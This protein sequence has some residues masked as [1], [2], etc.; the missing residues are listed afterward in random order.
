MIDAT[1]KGVKGY[2]RALGYDLH[3]IARAS[4][5]SPDGIYDLVHPVAT[6]CPWVRDG[7]FR[8]VYDQLDGFT[9]VD[10]YRC[11]E[12][13]H[14]V[15][16]SAKAAEG[17]LLEVGTWRGG[18]GCLIARAAKAAGIAGQVHLCDTFRG[19]VKAGAEDSTYR[20]GEH[21]DTNVD[22]VLALAR[23]LRVDDIRI[24]AGIFPEETGAA[25]SGRT[26][27]FCHIDVDVYGSCR[28]ILEWVWGRLARGGIIVY[29]D[30]G[31]MGCDGVRKHIEEQFALPDRVALYNLN[32]HGILVKL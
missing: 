23:R 27:R 7:A 31:M 5:T 22:F 8:E 1:R 32:G 4:E 18:T 26:F 28:D 19:V 9:M 6:Y 24:H 3:R 11:H 17:D 14:L 10:V 12:L 16:Q 25:I 20:G 15:A 21:A 29:D 13:W 30:Y 2:L